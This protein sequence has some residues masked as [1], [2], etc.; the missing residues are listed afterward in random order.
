MALGVVI[1]E[2]VVIVR[3]TAEAAHGAGVALADGIA[4]MDGGAGDDE[5]G[6]VDGADIG[7][8]LADVGGDLQ[9]PGVGDL[10]TEGGHRG[11]GEVFGVIT[12]IEQIADGDLFFIAD[13]F[14]RDGLPFR[15]GQRGQ[16]HGGQNRDDGDDHQQFDEG[17]R[18]AG[19]PRLAGDFSK[20][21]GFH[22]VGPTFRLKR[23]P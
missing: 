1:A 17:E 5:I 14:G 3:V 15:R 13:A 18:G 6:S 11:H 4:E 23:F 10:V 16:E 19:R 8:G 2:V 21:G 7:I 22:M 9:E 12:G 20:L